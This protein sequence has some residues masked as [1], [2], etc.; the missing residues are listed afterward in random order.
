[1]DPGERVECS[2][3]PAFHNSDWHYDDHMTVL[4]TALVIGGPDGSEP[5]EIDI[6]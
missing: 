3:G 4:L 6:E 2:C 5:V 1:M